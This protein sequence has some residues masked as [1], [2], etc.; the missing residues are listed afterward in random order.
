MFNHLR[1][2]GRG[3]FQSFFIFFTLVSRVLFY[4]L[5]SQ[6]V[7]VYW[8]I[9]HFIQVFNLSNRLAHIFP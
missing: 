8:E 9:F 4:C 6:L 2:V 5:S 3:A 1:V 7:N